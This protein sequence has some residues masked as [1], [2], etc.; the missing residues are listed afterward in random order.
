MGQQSKPSSFAVRTFQV[1]PGPAFPF[2]SL[3]ALTDSAS[4]PALGLDLPRLCFRH[5]GPR[6]PCL[7]SIASLKVCPKEQCFF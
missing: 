4:D 3:A 1:C 2:D 5:V 7:P 6:K